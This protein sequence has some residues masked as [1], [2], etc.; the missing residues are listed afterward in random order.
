MLYVAASSQKLCIQSLSLVSLCWSVRMQTLANQSF[1]MMHL[2]G[3]VMDINIT[4]MEI[5]YHYSDFAASNRF[6]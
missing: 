6:G 5:S 3:E 4:G 1:V 2:L